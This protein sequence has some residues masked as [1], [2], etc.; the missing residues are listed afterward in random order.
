MGAQKK[1]RLAIEERAFLM[2]PIAGRSNDNE[3]QGAPA[4]SFAPKHKG[5]L[6]VT[7]L[8]K[9][10]SVK[11]P[12]ALIGNALIQANRFGAKSSRIIKTLRPFALGVWG[13]GQAKYGVL[14]TATEQFHSG[15][16]VLKKDLVT[17]TTIQSD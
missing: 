7:D 5:K 12:A 14:A 10:A 17:E 13:L 3:P 9:L 2:E 6:F 16:G 8:M 4:R 15:Q 1:S 11:E